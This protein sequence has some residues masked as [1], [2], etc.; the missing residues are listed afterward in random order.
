MIFL[1]GF[2]IWQWRQ[3][4]GEDE[5]EGKR[6]EQRHTRPESHCWSSLVEWRGIESTSRTWGKLKDQANISVIEQ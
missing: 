6:C 1:G 3:G 2:T 4:A 5:E